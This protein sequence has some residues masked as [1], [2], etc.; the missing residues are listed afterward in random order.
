VGVNILPPQTDPEEGDGVATYDASAPI[1]ADISNT[2]LVS[3]LFSNIT[4]YE[5]MLEI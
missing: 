5:Q 1:I 3:L 4:E 2:G